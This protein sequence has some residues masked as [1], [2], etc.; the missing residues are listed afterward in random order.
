MRDGAQPSRAIVALTVGSAEADSMQTRC[1]VRVA[2]LS[3]EE[4]QRHAARTPRV[5][6]PRGRALKEPPTRRSSA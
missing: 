4:G 5:S 3:W 6:G 2:A 1:N